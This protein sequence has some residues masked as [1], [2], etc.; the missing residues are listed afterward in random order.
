MAQKAKKA[1]FS[2]KKILVIAVGVLLIVLLTAL[3]YLKLRPNAE[4]IVVAAPS[5]A[6]LRLDGKKIQNGARGIRTGK[7]KIELSLE[8]FETK[9]QEFEIS[10]GETQ[11]MNLYLVGENEDY[12]HYLQNEEDIKLL[13]LIGDETAK[14]VA[15]D[16][17][18]A[19]SILEILPITLVGDDGESSSRLESGEDC[20]RS[21]CL[22]ITDQG[23]A[24]KEKMLERIKSL[25]FDPDDYEI[26]YEL[27]D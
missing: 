6:T 15:S 13:G 2:Q 5:Q 26:Q 10:A 1:T 21:Y 22:K 4:L 16:Y 8:G 25:G 14:Q 11:S 27:V 17:W 24:L 20:A 18:A 9:T 3:I 12:S 19:K 7:H 23:E